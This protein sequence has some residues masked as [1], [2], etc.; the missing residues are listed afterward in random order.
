LQTVEKHFGLDVEQ[1]WWER[2]T[3]AATLNKVRPA[4][5]SPLIA[6]AVLTD[7]SRSLWSTW[8]ETAE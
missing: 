6:R 3:D 2:P 4:R 1:A 5:V 7:D 8:S